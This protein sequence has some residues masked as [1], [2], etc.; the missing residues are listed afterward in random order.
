MLKQRRLFVYLLICMMLCTLSVPAS[1]LKSFQKETGYTYFAFGSY[2]QTAAAEEK[3]VVW[4]VLQIKD[5]FIY[6]LSDAIL[7]TGRIDGQQWVYPGWLK[8]ELHEWLNDVFFNRAFTLDEQRAMHREEVLG[9]VSLPSVDDIRNPAFGFLGDKDRQLAGTDYALARGLYRYSSR[10]YSPIWT[11]TAS[12]KSHAHRSTKSGGGIGF[13]GV[14]SDDLGILPVI[15]LIE[16]EVQ[17][18]SGTGT[19]FSPYVLNKR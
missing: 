2:P 15:W 6:A 17:I 4:R 16:D 1:G 18:S 11:R 7:D 3:P 19:A 5:G 10:S 12:Q 13:I 14:E 9:Y 8:S